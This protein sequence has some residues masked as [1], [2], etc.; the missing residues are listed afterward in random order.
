MFLYKKI[1][2]YNYPLYVATRDSFKL[3]SDS[4]SLKESLV[5]VKIDEYRK[6][7]LNSDTQIMKVETK[8]FDPDEKSLEDFLDVIRISLKQII[9]Q[10]RYKIKRKWKKLKHFL[11][12]LILNTIMSTVSTK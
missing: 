11:R 2:E 7:L 9:S 1:G 4:T 12:N 5:G 10:K 3:V 8:A 6:T